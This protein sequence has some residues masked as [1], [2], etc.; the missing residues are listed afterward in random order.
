MVLGR[1]IMRNCCVVSA[2]WIDVKPRPGLESGPPDLECSALTIRPPRLPR[3]LKYSEKRELAKT[4]RELLQLKY[5][6]IRHL[7][8]A[9]PCVDKDL[10]HRARGRLNFTRM[11]VLLFEGRLTLTSGYIKQR[12]KF[13]PHFQVG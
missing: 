10:H 3:E 2:G 9:R 6:C 4:R 11:S 5:K 1:L 8:H 13:N 12:V 7:I